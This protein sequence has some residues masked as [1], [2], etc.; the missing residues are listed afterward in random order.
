METIDTQEYYGG[1]YP[2]MPDPDEHEYEDFDY[3]DYIDYYYEMEKDRI[4]MAS[5][6]RDDN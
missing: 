6:E 2:S 1:T 3:G 4:L 5:I